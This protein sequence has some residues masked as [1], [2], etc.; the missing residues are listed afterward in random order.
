MTHYSLPLEASVKHFRNK[1]PITFVY[2]ESES[3]RLAIRDA[4]LPLLLL[5]NVKTRAN[6]G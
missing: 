6:E 2:Q 4:L 3:S 1:L 5:L